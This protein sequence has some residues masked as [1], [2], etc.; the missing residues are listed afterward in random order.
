MHLN[1]F[2]NLILLSK[3]HKNVFKSKITNKK[4]KKLVYIYWEKMRESK[5][6]DE[7]VLFSCCC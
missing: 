1:L 2:I 4:K 7:C 3:V 6:K 5:N